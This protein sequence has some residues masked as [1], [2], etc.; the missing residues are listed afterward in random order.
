[1]TAARSLDAPAGVGMVA[2]AD[3]LPVGAAAALA[4]ALGTVV[5]TAATVGA[6]GE[7]VMTGLLTALAG[8]LGMPVVPWLEQPAASVTRSVTLTTTAA[9]VPGV[10]RLTPVPW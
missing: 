1:L 10:R 2:T 3:G 6:D 9:A 5:T 8:V 4:G 7:V